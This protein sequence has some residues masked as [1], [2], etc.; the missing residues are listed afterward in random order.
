MVKIPLVLWLCR[1]SCFVVAYQFHDYQSLVP[2]VWC[3]HSTLFRHRPRF[4][5]MTVYIYL[6]IMYLTYLYYFVINVYGMLDWSTDKDTTVKNYRYGLFNFRNPEWIYPSLLLSVAFLALYCRM[7][8]DEEALLEEKGRKPKQFMKYF[9]KYAPTTHAF[10]YLTL[11][12]IDFLVFIYCVIYS[13][14]EMNLF[15]VTILFVMVWA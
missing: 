15:H 10:F 8:R 5:F 7:N 1:I 3:M 6:P 13:L 14:I 11:V 9:S 12:N 2:L 4:V